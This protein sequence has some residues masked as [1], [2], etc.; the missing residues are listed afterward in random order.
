MY[1]RYHTLL[2]KTE[3]RDHIRAKHALTREPT[4]S[5]WVGNGRYYPRHMVRGMKWRGTHPED[6]LHNERP[7]YVSCDEDQRFGEVTGVVEG[8][9]S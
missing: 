6:D 1:T 8:G 2:W 3:E 7:D 9:G 4:M 5:W